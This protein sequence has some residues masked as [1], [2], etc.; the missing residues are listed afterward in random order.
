M[1]TKDTRALVNF[2]CGDDVQATTHCMRWISLSFFFL[3]E[4]LATS[5]CVEEKEK[6]FLLLFYCTLPSRKNLYIFFAIKYYDDTKNLLF[7]VCL[8]LFFIWCFLQHTNNIFCEW[9]AVKMKQQSQF[10]SLVYASF[11][12]SCSFIGEHTDYALP[13]CRFFNPMTFMI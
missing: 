9:R 10:S 3:T 11:L 13:Y 6:N 12:C 5:N 8:L 4:L 1:L 2:S 7:Y